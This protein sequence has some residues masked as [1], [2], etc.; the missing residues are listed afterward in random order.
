MGIDDVG[1]HQLRCRIASA[2][3][4]M[5][6]TNRG[7]VGEVLVAEA[8][9][10][11]VTDGWSDWDVDLACGTRVEVKTTG[12]IQ[13]WPQVKPSEPIWSI[14][15]SEGWV[16]TDGTYA[17]DPNLERRSDVYVF[18]I[19]LGVRPDVRSE[20]RFYVVPTEQID[21]QL[22][23]QKTITEL[24]L[25]QQFGVDRNTYDELSALRESIASR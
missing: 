7:I 6:N 9:D 17:S 15:R 14:A 23:D 25:I 12:C 8:L 21:I 24:S 2:I 11:V 20:W 19:H 3:N 4:L 13:A 10:G 18:A 1:D 16:L 5:D 22:P